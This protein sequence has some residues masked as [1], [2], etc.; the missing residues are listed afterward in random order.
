MNKH[1]VKLFP[2]QNEQAHGKTIFF[3]KMNKHILKLFPFQNEQTRG[4]TISFSK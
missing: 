4:K 1:A 2:F 3:V